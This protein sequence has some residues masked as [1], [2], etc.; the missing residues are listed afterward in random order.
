MDSS[1]SLLDFPHLP[2]ARV[3]PSPLPQR[4]WNAIFSPSVP[5]S[6]KLHLSHF[7]EE[8][9][10]VPFS[11]EKLS[12]GA[13]DWSRCLVG[14]SIG[15]RPYYEALLGAIKKTWKLKGS[16]EMFS[17]SDGFF[18]FRFSCSEDFD[19]VW[20]KGIWFLLGKPFIMQKWHPK[21]KPKRENFTSIPIWV[22]IH[23]LPLACWNS[24]GISRIA[25]KI[26]IPLAADTLTTKKTRLT[27]ARVCVL[28]DCHASYPEEIK[29]SL[30]GDIVALK[31]Q[32]EWR[33]SPCAHCKSLVH[34]SSFCP[35]KPQ[36]EG[37]KPNGF[38]NNLPPRGRSHSRKPNNRSVSKP[39]AGNLASSSSPALVI[40]SR[41]D[42]PVTESAQG[43]VSHSSLV[44]SGTG[45]I[46][47]AVE[48]NE[49]G[50]VLHYQ[51]HSP[52]SKNPNSDQFISSLNDLKSRISEVQEEGVA[53]ISGQAIPNLNSP[54]ADNSISTGG[55]ST[56]VVDSQGIISPNRFDLLKDNEEVSKP[57]DNTSSM[58]S[59]CP[60]PKNKSSIKPQ[61]QANANGN[62][63]KK[64]ARGKQSKKPQSSS[65]S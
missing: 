16:L 24:E 38:S 12:T 49:L 19:T 5:S 34:F 44:R 61:T 29:V 55:I 39:P 51:P 47:T 11:G 14:Y 46:S 6:D 18:L 60:G 4:N 9:D 27:Y 17:L 26:G 59:G 25:S 7:P 48:M 13:E 42:P 63:G 8:P 64:S 15:R 37:D 10:I 36:E 54:T 43:P 65:S 35:S 20:T 53:L 1:S 3:P 57:E 28:V 62:G 23:D 22:K 30:D 31:V 56:S 58:N 2:S 21:F 40:N 41:S 50:H 32:Y 33:P 52:S 45:N